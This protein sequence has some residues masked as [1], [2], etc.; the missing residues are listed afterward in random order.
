MIEEGVDDDVDCSPDD[1]G[2]RHA[3]PRHLNG[4]SHCEEHSENEHER[5]P[6]LRA[7]APWSQQGSTLQERKEAL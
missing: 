5:G 6:A 2:L 7:E 1:R 3:G 4:A